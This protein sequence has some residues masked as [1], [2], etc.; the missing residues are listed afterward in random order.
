MPSPQG[1]YWIGTTSATDFTFPSPLPRGCVYAKGQQE[2]GEGGF[3]HW[4]WIVL[5]DKPV[6]LSVVRSLFS[7][8]WELT[9]SDA[10]LSYVWK[11]DTRVAD[12]QFEIGSL[13]KKRNSKVD[14]DE[15]RR[16]AQRGDL[17]TIPADIYVRCYGNLKRISSDC[18]QPVPMERSVFVFWGATGTG[19][20]RTAWEQ[21]GLDAYSKDPRTKWWD[22]YTGQQ[23]V[24]IDEFRGDIHL[25]HILRW[26]DRYPVRVE[27]KGSTCAFNAS[28]IWITSNLNP[29]SEWFPDTD[30]SSVD[31]LMR[32]LNITHFNY[33]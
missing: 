33:F 7:G 11:E 31:A 8:H 5:F 22:G 17:E 28:S 21:A 3:L 32:R 10:A 13:P 24:V 16:L 27:S 20:S 14:W 23:H 25:S 9:R 19:K 4:Q 18:L 15:V 1:R 29:R 26:F 30:V 12:T 2:S 6:R